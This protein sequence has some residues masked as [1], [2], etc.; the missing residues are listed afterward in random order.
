MLAAGYFAAL[1]RT[2]GGTLLADQQVGGGIAW[3]IGELPTLAWRV[4]AVQWSRQRR[5]GGQT[6]GPGRRP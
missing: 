3:G 6:A 5:P 1:G 2:W 4:L